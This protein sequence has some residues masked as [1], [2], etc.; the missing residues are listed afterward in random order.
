MDPEPWAAEL[1]R[2]LYRLHA[3]SLPAFGRL[4]RD[5]R[6]TGREE[7]AGHE[8]RRRAEGRFES[9]AHGLA[10]ER[11]RRLREAFTRLSAPL[12]GSGGLRP[13]LVHGDLV[14][15]HVLVR[16]DPLTGA[17]RLSGLVDWERARAADP[18]GEFAAFRLEWGGRLS[19]MARAVERA[20]LALAAAEGAP[21]R[22]VEWERRVAVALV[23]R[24]LDARM[25]ARQRLA[26][27][28][29]EEIDRR[30][31]LALDDGA[32]GA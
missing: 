3:I 2:A 16:P 17:A 4:D 26:S 1:A 32:P 5:G 27:S 29:L 6:P 9:P 19:A 21:G 31:D 12:C 23:P 30:L 28:E 11:L 8:A 10:P 13:A 14:P 7:D 25:A 18:A 24:L 20:Y 15:G 22:V